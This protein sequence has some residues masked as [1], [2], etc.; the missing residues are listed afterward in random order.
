MKPHPSFLVSALSLSLTLVLAGP[1]RAGDVWPQ[2]RGPTGDGHAQATGLPLRWSETENVVWKTA[3]HDKGWSSPVIWGRQIWLTTALEDG[4]ELFA[5]CI[6]RDSGKILHDIK[7]FEVEKPGF[8]PPFN[9]YASPTPVIEEGRVYI[10]FG[11]PGTAC[12]D[13]ATGKVLWQRRD[14]PCDHWRAAGSSPVLAGGLLILTFDGYD[15][16]YLVGLDRKTGAT[17]WKKDREIKY[18]P[19]AAKN[20]DLKKAYSTPQVVTI[21]GQEQ[22][23]SPSAEATIA[24]D[25]RTGV[26]IWRVSHTG[27][28][29]ATRPLFG[30]GRLFLTTGH[31]CKLLALH[32]E[33]DGTF[34]RNG[35]DW[36]SNKGVPSRP[37]L[38]LIGDQLFMVSDKGIA[39]CVDV[40]TGEQLG[41]FRLGGGFSG[42]P[43]YADG[44]IY[45]AG[46]EG[47]T[48]V[49]EPTPELKILAV[50][51]LD[52]G[53][54][55]S[56]A[57]VGKALY[58][59]TR[60]HLYRLEQ[61]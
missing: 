18:T 42:S 17:V 59:R 10:H 7:L 44:R 51:K 43:V 25:P 21:Q 36:T 39:S 48:Y 12:L 46:E 16:Q 61:K 20:G 3:I 22:L 30:Q 35:I 41:Q 29:A 27:M 15:Q 53:C 38:L 5:L 37:S 19:S 14:L 47:A 2:F 40:K 54:M 13:T 60:T 23:I 32:P 9:S 1:G 49:V 45:F 33:A 28:N 8:C 31:D 26:E 55:A 52:Q 57:V 34:S 4:K 50:N 56:P 11:S 24:Y 58:L 6:D